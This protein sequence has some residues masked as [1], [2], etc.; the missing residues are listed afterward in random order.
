MQKLKKSLKQLKFRNLKRYFTKRNIIFSLAIIL[1]LG[2]YIQVQSVFG[3]F[4][5]LEGKDTSLITEIG[6]IKDSYIKIGQDL[7]DARM[8]LG[9][10][11][12]DYSSLEADIDDEE[13]NE[14][15]L[16]MAMFQYLESLVSDKAVKE[17]LSFNKSLLTNLA[18]S[19]KFSTFL[20]GNKL[21]LMPLIQ[22]D[23]AH[24][25]NVHTNKHDGLA[26]FYLSKD[27]G[28]LIFKTINEKK[29]K[30]YDSFE[31]FEDEL[32]KFLKKNVENLL[33]DGQELL[34]KKKQI[35]EAIKLPE[36]QTAL[37]QLGFKLN[38]LYKD[39]DL[40]YTYSVYNKSGELIGEIVLHTDTRAIWLV[41]TKNSLATIQATDL[42]SALPP[43]LK[44]LDYQNSTQK[45][46]ADV[47]ENLKNSINDGGF[48]LLLKQGKMS[49]SSK[50]REDNQRYY[51]DLYEGKKHISSIV[52]EKST[53]VVNIVKP[54]GTNAENLLFFDPILKKKT[55]DIPD[56]VPD[57]GNEIS[58]NEGVLNILV[59]GKQGMNVD[60]M[61]LAHL[62][63]KRRS[64][65]MVSIPRDLMY[66]GRK[67]NSLAYY[68]GMPE[69]KKAVTKISGYNV[70]KYILID[71]YA[72]IDVVDLI[73]GVDIHL[74]APLVDPSYKVVDNGIASTLHYDEGDH[75]LGGVQAL[76]VAR[77][78]KTTSD[79]SR[80]ERQ[81]EIL[82]AIQDKARNFGFGDADT[83]YQIVKTVLNKT[84]TDISLDEALAFFFRYQNYD[85]DSMSVMHSAN[86]LF[87]PP[88]VTTENC[89][90]ML[91][92]AAAAGEPKPDCEGQNHAYTLLPRDNN[93][94]LIK[95]FFKEHFEEN[96]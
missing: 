67:I 38:P 29:K 31:E 70:D 42:K 93:W 69:L 86:V 47:M 17:K 15:E 74:T 64:I 88:Y 63:D 95:W 6:Q 71:M 52:V 92:S 58:K 51:F 19:K 78:R 56:S 13:K 81:Q 23:E 26:T 76:R 18:G 43:F 33:A 66:N 8:Y 28:V 72:F 77:S 75:H 60:T 2:M 79:F 25:L 68:Y 36:T 7:N 55:L 9:M 94:N 65:S 44:K 87:V 54:D 85:I 89:A 5:L 24:I 30:T 53:G 37:K 96:K 39:S 41:D 73:G 12:T 48:Q 40:K 10:Q 22:D 50:P 49:M 84:E 46:V 59:T 3:T 32:I 57:Y 90:A 83:I 80:A 21:M 45:K 82:A 11:T 20:S 61:I 27:D 4:D 62:D 14:D 16:Q 91:A 34:K 35:G 1:F